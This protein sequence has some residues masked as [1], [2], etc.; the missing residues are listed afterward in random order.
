MDGRKKSKRSRVKNPG[1]KKQ[2]NS[3]VKQEYIDYDYVDKLSPE[4]AEWLNKFSEEYIGAKLNHHDALH[5]TP[6]LRKDCFDRNNARQRCIYGN[7]K[8]KNAVYT[9]TKH[10]VGV[11]NETND[12]SNYNDIMIN[13]QQHMADNIEDHMIDYIDIKRKSDKSQQ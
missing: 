13:K 4:E 1:L 10:N 2:Y 6:E 7:S 8:A 5:D 11:N 9:P 12:V 3:K